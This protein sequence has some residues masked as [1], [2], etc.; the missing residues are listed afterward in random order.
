M[1]FEW[2]LHPVTT[3]A[4]AAAGLMLCLYLFCSAK[5]E[6]RMLRKRTGERADELESAVQRM[7]SRLNELETYVKEAQW[8]TA[9]ASTQTAV[10]LTRRAKALR[11]YRRGESAPSIAA[12]LGAP[13]NEVDLLIKI[14]RIMTQPQSG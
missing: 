4:A 2:I 12:G 3:Y 10:N 14:Y 6:T 9:G 13:R 1:N 7:E 11:M 8:G 5:G